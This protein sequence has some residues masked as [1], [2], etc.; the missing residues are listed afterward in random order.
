MEIDKHFK[1]WNEDEW[2]G[3]IWIMYIDPTKVL[4]AL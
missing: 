3:Y 1:T 4:A 2:Y